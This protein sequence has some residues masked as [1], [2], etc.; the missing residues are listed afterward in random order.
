MAGVLHQVPAVGDLIGLRQGLRG[1]QCIFAPAVSCD[2]F[3]LGLLGQPGLGGHRLPIWQ[4]CD[5]HSPLQIANDRAIT[6]IA[7]PSPIIDA[8]D[9]RW[10]WRRAIVSANGSQQRII[11]NRKSETT[12]KS[13]CRTAAQRKA[14]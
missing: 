10:R 1:T 11:A 4:E 3:D 12:R 8:D 2:D 14:R 7:A 9:A 6:M 13:R 5:R